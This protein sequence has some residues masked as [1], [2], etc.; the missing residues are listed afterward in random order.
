MNTQANT[1][2][3]SASKAL[4]GPVAQFFLWFGAAVSMAEI[5]T[6]GFFAGLDWKAALGLIIAGHLAGGVVLFFVARHSYRSDAS[7]I[8]SL[9][10]TFGPVGTIVAAALN[11]L[12]LV[13]W[14]IVMVIFAGNA[15]VDLARH[16]GW[17][18]PQTVWF[19]P[20]TKVVVGLAI[21]LWLALGVGGLR[22]VNIVVV[23]LLFALTIASAILLCWQQSGGAVQ[24]SGVVAQNL[25]PPSWGAAFELAIIMPLSWLPL[26]GDYTRRSVSK[27]SGPIAAAVGYT[28][29]SC[30]MYASG[31]LNMSASGNADPTVILGS[32]GW[33]VAAV[34][35]ILFSTTTTAY[36]DVHSAAVSAVTALPALAGQDRKSGEATQASKGRITLIALVVCALSTIV[37]IWFPLDKYQDFLYLIGSVFAPLYGVLLSDS[38]SLRHNPA[39]K[40]AGRPIHGRVAAGLVAWVV[41]FAAYRLLNLDP[42]N[43]SVTPLGTSLPVLLGSGL[44]AWALR[45]AIKNVWF[46]G[47]D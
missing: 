14:T 25:T 36:L 9:R 43:P 15:L 47:R 38:F 30:W 28:L 44:L 45:V 5:A 22:S 17:A 20:A 12:Q 4:L 37:S 40:P 23:L 33:G 13:G 11:V 29:G 31:F 8:E 7:A 19:A 21:A 2:A 32:V 41:G 24:A 27:P 3:K 10:P 35:V 46:K 42:A 39:T 1:Q 34:L 6:G 16:A 26:V 18:A